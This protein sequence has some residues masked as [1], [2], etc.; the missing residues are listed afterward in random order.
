VEVLVALVFISIFSVGVVNL[1]VGVLHANRQAK[2]MDIAVFLA[3][4]RLEAIR[5]TPYASVTAANFPAEGYG[6]I[7]VGTPTPVSYPE[8]QR[9]VSITDNTPITGMKRVI[10]TVSWRSGSIFEEILVGQ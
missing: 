8:F 10:V 1:A 2:S 4:D 5:N 9:W 7:T 3:H 6:A